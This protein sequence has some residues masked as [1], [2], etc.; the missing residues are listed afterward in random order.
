MTKQ[1]P[2]L[3]RADLAG[4]SPEEI[5]E[6]RHE[7]KLNELMGGTPPV[8]T[9]GDEQLTLAAVRQMTPDQIIEARRTGRLDALL[10]GGED[11]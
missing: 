7:G 9:S 4:M 6:A 5:N 11:N 10:S 2:Q 8:D 1:L 3:T